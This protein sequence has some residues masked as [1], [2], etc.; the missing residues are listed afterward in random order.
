MPGVIKLPTRI[1]PTASSNS[2]MPGQTSLRRLG[3]LSLVNQQPLPVLTSLDPLPPFESLAPQELPFSKAA[4][5]GLPP[6]ALDLD[7]PDDDEEVGAAAALEGSAAQQQPTRARN[8]KTFWLQSPAARRLSTGESAALWNMRTCQLPAWLVPSSGGPSLH[9]KAFVYS[10]MNSL[11]SNACTDHA[12]AHR[13]VGQLIQGPSDA[14]RLEAI[15]RLHAM[16]F[17]GTSANDRAA[18]EVG[19]RGLACIVQRALSMPHRSGL[20]SPA[21]ARMQNPMSSS[22]AGVLR[23]LK[24]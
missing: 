23:A 8:S 7:S 5:A 13:L 19:R 15:F 9:G 22:C 24:Q 14:A 18:A 16:L 4:A 20:P 3:S 10:L 11:V 1:D 12:G 21:G 17:G 6:A 2:A